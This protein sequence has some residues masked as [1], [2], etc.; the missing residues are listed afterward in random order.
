MPLLS[1]LLAENSSNVW[2]GL[3]FFRILAYWQIRTR[4]VNPLK[5]S[6]FAILF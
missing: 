2:A 5:F 4:L 3:T 6:R 1:A